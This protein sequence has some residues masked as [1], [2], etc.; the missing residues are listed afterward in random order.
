MAC[1]QTQLIKRP[2]YIVLTLYLYS[3]VCTGLVCTG[4]PELISDQNNTNFGNSTKNFC[5]IADQTSILNL[6]H[7]AD[8]I[9][10]VR[11]PVL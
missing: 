2:D 1:V 9:L 10:A 11:L 3:L 7:P 4:I 8:L 6:G 5:S